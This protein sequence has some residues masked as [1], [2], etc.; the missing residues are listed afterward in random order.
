MNPTNRW[1]I[2]KR[3]TPIVFSFYMAAIMAFLMTAVIL[4]VNT[5]LGHDY[6]LRVL[7]AYAL[8]APIGFA[9]VLLTRPLVMRLVQWT[10]SA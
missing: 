6:L 3:F 7:R 2:P 8:A 5:G 9:C 4:G 1:K 10:V